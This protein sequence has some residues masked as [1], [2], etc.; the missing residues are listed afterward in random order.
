MSEPG[1]DTLDV[2]YD[3]E[4][5]FCSRYATMVQLREKG[6]V[7][8]LHDARDEGTYRRFPTALRFDLDEG[9]LARWQEQWFHGSEAVQVISRLSRTAP[10]A[11]LMRNDEVSAR[12]YPLLRAVRHLTLRL[13]GRKK[14]N[15]SPDHR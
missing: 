7:V 3:G 5:P 8:R 15:H 14:I 6:I 1:G 13:L 11:A 4:C 9:M 10:V 2:I 12:L